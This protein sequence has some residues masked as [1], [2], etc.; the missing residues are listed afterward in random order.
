MV[1]DRVVRLTA[2][3][4]RDLSEHLHVPVLL[5]VGTASPR[6]LYVTDA[7]AAV[8]SDVRIEALSGQAHDGMTTGGRFS[9]ATVLGISD[10]LGFG[11]VSLTAPRLQQLEG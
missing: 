7:L 1:P 5:Q 11:V 9:S 2:K 6:A 4:R 8:L 3:E 10:S